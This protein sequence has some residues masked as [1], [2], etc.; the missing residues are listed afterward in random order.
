MSDITINRR[1][2][3]KRMDKLEGDVNKM[4]GDITDIKTKIY[5]GMGTSIKNTE[6]RLTRFEMRY[7]IGHENLIKKLDKILFLWISGSITLCIG[8]VLYIVS[9]AL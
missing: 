3:D 5:N 4:Q 9:C 2:E 6:E 8:F 7:D 1:Y